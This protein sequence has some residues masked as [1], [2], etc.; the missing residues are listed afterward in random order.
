MKYCLSGRQ[1]MSV[2][3]RADEIRVRYED[4][5][6]ILDYIESLP[7]KTIILDIP[8]EIEEINW[9]LL[10][11]Y[12]EK[13]SFMVCLYDLKWVNECR[14]C[15]IPFFWG[16]P[17]TSYYELE[18]ILALNPCYIFLGA[19]LCF[20]LPT[21]KA[22]AACP[23]RLCPNLAY[24]AYIP[25][26]NGI[27]GSWIRPEDVDLYA[28]YVDTLEFEV[29]ELQREQVLFHVYK[30]NKEWP[31]NLNLLITNLNC[32]VDNRMIPKDLG[33]RRISC[34]Q[35]CMHGT[36]HFCET[37]MLF[38]VAVDKATDNTPPFVGN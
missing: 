24:D 9:N 17:I 7:T 13:I 21:V 37:A 20:D 35:H 28:E 4:K 22:R 18:G 16:Y 8:R 23:I 26:K 27:C 29:N 11:M 6:R 15:G 3:K 14:D 31:G 12:A 33:T 5:D 2:L 34:K 36:C 32:N 1:S 25:R 10:K 19:P 30:D 38:A